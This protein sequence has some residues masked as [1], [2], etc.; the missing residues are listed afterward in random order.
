MIRVRFFLGLILLA[1]ISM[2]CSRSAS[3]RQM[4]EVLQQIHQ[5]SQV[6]DN[7]FAPEAKVRFYD[8]LVLVATSEQQKITNHY[9]KGYFLL[10]TGEAE[11]AIEVYKDL[12]GRMNPDE[13]EAYRLVNLYLGVAYLRLGEQMNCVSNKTSES[14]IYPI[15]GTGIHLENSGSQNA[16]RHFE[17]A[18]QLDPNDLEARWLLNIAY[19]TLGQYP[20]K[21]PTELLIPGLDAASEKQVNPFHEISGVLGLTIRDMSGGV[22][23]D[24]FNQDGTLDIVTS[25]WGLDEP[26]KFWINKGDGTFENASQKSNLGLLMGGL[27][28]MQTDY[29][30]DGLLDIF[31]LRGGWMSRYGRQPNSL[32]RNNGDGTFSDVTFESGMVSYIPTQTATWNDFNNDGWLDV[33]I[34]NETNQDVYPCELYINQKDGTFLNLANESGA[35]IIDYV[36]GVSS[37]DFNNDGWQ[38]IFISTMNRKSY[39]L[40]NNGVQ[41]GQLSFQDVTAEAGLDLITSKTFPT[42]FWDYNNDGM[43][44]IFLCGYEFEKSLGYY[45]ASEKLGQPQREELQMK[46]FKNNGNGT[47]TNVAR[48]VG[49]NRVVN[50]MGSNFGDFDYDGNLDFYLG[51]GNP[52]TKSIIP[53]R[54]FK[55]EAGIFYDVTAAARVGHL[56]KGHA[57]AF[58]D[59]DYD[60]DQDIFAQ[61]GGSFKGESFQNSFY[62]NPGQGGNN[63]IG[64]RLEGVKSNRPGIGSRIKVTVT[65]DGKERVIHRDLNSGGSFGASPLMAQI[66]IGKAKKIDHLQI[67]WAG[68]NTKQTFTEVTPNQFIK[69]KEDHPEI[70]SLPYTRISFTKE[71][72]LTP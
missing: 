11:Q 21:V 8:S 20:E 34:G 65:E 4:A 18:L 60:G 5:Q 28:M 59:L 24:D 6:R 39:L 40:K 42:W 36:K 69:I 17:T 16:I 2:S 19:M 15:A 33:F 38:D 35:G 52:D 12:L 41:N 53:N 57:V 46:L 9:F 32:L 44:D 10:Q 50:A 68:S 64:I 56:Q 27:N 25:A 26:M 55:N 23:I 45:E 31:V 71:P 72:N 62:L 66:G 29:N 63:W 22:I 13:K 67:T 61:V 51:T 48:E 37:G 47:F 30:N 43:M 14:C 58:A 54:L 3:T 7:F 49:L 1:G 70:I